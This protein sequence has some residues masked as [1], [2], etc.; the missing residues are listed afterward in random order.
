MEK[1]IFDIYIISGNI[2]IFCGAH[3]ESFKLDILHACLFAELMAAK[4][5][6]ARDVSWTTYKATLSKLSWITKSRTIQHTDF[7]KKSLLSLVEQNLESTLPT[8]EQLVIAD[9][10]SGIVK[11]PI[12]SLVVNTIIEKLQ[13]NASRVS[14]T[15]STVST[16]TLVTIVHTDKSVTTLQVAFNTSGAITAGILDQPVIGTIKDGKANTWLL[17]STL[18]SRQYDLIRDEVIKKLGRRIE[19]DMIHVHMPI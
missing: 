7:N 16:A 8:H 1:S 6:N 17:C 18:D 11:L 4:Q 5:S 9:A 12:N 19:T 15:S 14:D 13:T 10:L 3:A 2:T